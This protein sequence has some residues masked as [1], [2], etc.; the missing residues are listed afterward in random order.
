MDRAVT[1]PT[2][3]AAGAGMIG[4]AARDNQTFTTTY[5]CAPIR[6]K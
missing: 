2:K 3:A 6:F 5:L 4:M 1:K